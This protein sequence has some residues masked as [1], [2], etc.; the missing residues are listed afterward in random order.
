MYDRYRIVVT[1]DS[2]KDLIDMFV[3]AYDNLT[4][5]EKERAPVVVQG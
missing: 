5:K 3:K 4:N 1:E 2:N